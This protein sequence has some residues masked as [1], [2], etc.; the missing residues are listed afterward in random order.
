MLLNLGLVV[1]HGDL[2]AELIR[3][4]EL[5]LGPVQGMASISNQGLSGRDLKAEIQRWLAENADPTDASV[6]IFV[7]DYGGSCATAVQLVCRHRTDVAILTGVNLAMILGFLTWRDTLSLAELSR[8]LVD[9]GRDAINQIEFSEGG[10][11]LA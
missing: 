5:V 4:A 6:V 11:N 1:T 7:D 2:G 3:L 9:T 10:G 8:K